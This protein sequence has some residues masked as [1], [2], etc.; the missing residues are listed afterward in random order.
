MIGQVL[1]LALAGST[2]SAAV[3]LDQAYAAA[4]ARSESVAV[5]AEQ[6]VQAR[7][8]VK[9][10]GGAVL[11]TVSGVASYLWQQEVKGAL[12]QSI[13]P[14]TQPYA[15]IT[16][17]QPLFRGL[18]EFAALRQAR[19]L[20]TSQE[21]A[22]R[23]TRIQLFEDVVQGYY[24]VLAAE[25]DQR[26]L[27]IE[28]DAY[29]KRIDELND[30][31]KSGR[32]RVSEVLAARSARA[33]LEAQAEAVRGQIGATRDTLA[34]LTGMDPAVS[35]SDA[36]PD[37]KPVS[38]LTDYLPR[39]ADRPD[40]R[41]AD[42]AAR[43]AAEGVSYAWGAYLPSVDLIGNYYLKRTGLL[44]DSHWDAQVAL[45]VPLFTGGVTTS[46]VREAR[47]VARQSDQGL[48]RARRLGEQQ[49][50]LFYDRAASDRA[51]ADALAAAA[52][53][54]EKNYAEQ[55]R[56]Y[57]LGLV[58]NLDV[59]QALATAREA[60]RA[61]AHARFALK[62]DLINLDAAAARRPAPVATP[63]KGVPAP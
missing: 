34:F 48:S 63:D 50:R 53:A 39:L 10:A 31:V 59:L 15:K 20:V 41:S 24:A 57:Q 58:T 16:A 7:E 17:D 11:P 56:E 18:R 43:A 29:A 45:T 55:S 51:Q 47:S 4:V 62:A 26:E 22:E 32:S 44:E 28:L 23:Q 40:I 14:T 42:L 5:A 35:L 13:A 3:T 52:D 49:L 61:A 37:P 36:E 12:G 38:P 33:S 2:E 25:E 21:E 27:G 6:V 1:A 60:A 54:A 8:H 9:Q 30:R 19:L 46:R